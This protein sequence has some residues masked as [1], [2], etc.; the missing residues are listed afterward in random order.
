MISPEVRCIVGIDVAKH[1]HVVC[2]LEAP[3]GA[4]RQKPFA[5]EASAPGYAALCERLAGWGDCAQILVGLEATGPLWEPLYEALT[6]AGYEV[7]LLNPRQTATWA[8]SLGLRAKTDPSV[9]RAHFAMRCIWRPSSRR[10]VL[11]SGECATSACSS[12]AAPRKRPSTSWR[13][14]SYGSS[15]SSCAP[16]RRMILLCLT[17]RRRPV[18]I[19]LLTFNMNSFSPGLPDSDPAPR[20]P[21]PSPPP[22]SERAGA[23]PG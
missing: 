6:Q 3:S 17:G 4:V 20:A 18:N 15:T 2:A 1:A 10:A 8:A 19:Q 12:V 16:V 21:H 7:L 11:L 14:R 23:H 13:G 5:I 9:V 22:Q